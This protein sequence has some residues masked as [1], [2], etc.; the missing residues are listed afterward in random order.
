MTNDTTNA[1]IIHSNKL[2][3]AFGISFTNKNVNFVKND[4]FPEGV[5]YTSNEGGVF[6]SGQKVYVKELV[7][8]KTKKNVYKAAVKGKDIVA[9]A[10]SIGKGKVF[11][12][13]DPWLYNEYLNGRKLPYDYKNY[14]AAIQLVQWLLK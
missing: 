4:N 10:A 5:V 7:T 9:A 12:I 3:Q 6:T 13:G 2:A 14:D 1:D 8:L 11:I